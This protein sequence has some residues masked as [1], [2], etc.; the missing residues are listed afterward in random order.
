MKISVAMTLY[1]P[2][3]FLE[4][5]LR[6]ILTQTRPPDEI[7]L[8]DDAPEPANAALVETL[9][10]EF[11][12]T[13]L[14]Y[15]A[16]PRTLGA[17]RNFASVIERTTGELIFLSDQDDV[18]LPEKIERL[19]AAAG[20]GGAFCN[21]TAVDA[22][23]R[24]LGFTHWNTRHYAPIPD[25]EHQFIFFLRRVPAAGHNMVFHARW[26]DLL[27]PFPGLRGCYDS[28][29]GLMIATVAEW[30]A[31]DRELTLY[32]V[33]GNNLSRPHA[34]G[35]RAQL[36]A[37]EESRANDSV[38]WMIE[39]LYAV[40]LRCDEHRIALDPH[41]RTL[42]FDRLRHASAREQLPER[43]LPKLT[44]VSRELFSGRYSRW[45]HGWRNAVQDLFFR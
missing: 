20:E 33:H 36:A 42:F 26:K 44:T 43:L 41:R 45:G 7:V 15:T 34:P 19:S 17:D 32:R 14:R 13:E 12:A 18:W 24:P 22:D 30:H 9:Q 29:I 37:L 35:L 11:P 27:L 2:G 4:P 39:L 8:G 5:Q 21:S 25:P 31:V 40:L 28:W 23:L 3:T 6:S 10:R 16:N 1:H 38:S